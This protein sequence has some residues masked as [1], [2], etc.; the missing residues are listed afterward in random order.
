MILPVA[1]EKVWISRS[2]EAVT[3][4]SPSG[5]IA[6]AHTSS[7]HVC[8]AICTIYFEYVHA[9]MHACVDE[10]VS[11]SVKESNKTRKWLAIKMQGLYIP[12]TN[13]CNMAYYA[14]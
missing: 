9:C 11:R 1:R 13:Y 5:A 4:V 7:V 2:V 10:S 6:T 14:G 12:Y 3:S 8:M